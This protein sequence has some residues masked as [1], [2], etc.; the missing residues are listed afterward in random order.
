MIK[1]LIVDDSTYARLSI[2]RRFSA[3]PEIEIAGCAGDGLEALEKIRELKPDV[4][5][6]DVIMP[7]LDGLETL[8]RI[9]T[10]CPTP[11]VMLSS[12]T[13]NGTDITVRALEMGAVDFFLKSSPAVPLGHY[14]T[15]NELGE[16]V[17]AAARIGKIR[18]RKTGSV[19]ENQAAP[20]KSVRVAL[21]DRS[22]VVVVAS[23]TGGP[24]ALYELFSRI[25]AGINAGFLV[26]Q[27]MPPVFTASL[28]GRLDDISPLDVREAVSGDVLGEGQ[29]LVAP[30][31]FH[32]VVDETRSIE[33]K[34]SAPVLN[35]R[36]A[37]DVTMKSAARVYGE[38]VL[39]VVLTGMGT[40]GTEGAAEVK[41]QG[42]HV[43]TQDEAS[44]VIYGMPQSVSESGNSDMELPLA[45]IAEGI[46][47]LCREFSELTVTQYSG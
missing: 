10:E 45:R 27:H 1:V 2:I 14:G 20:G 42:G 26:V 25:P 47:S 5:T 4:V 7:R 19:P 24:G 23:S 6:L 22:R 9:M 16:K 3:D 38:K 15:A 44:C 13:G 41:K 18:L 35:L 29:V 43:I 31:D 36:P 12:L 30:G 11:V 39:G 34:K 21:S 46:E 32:M 8:H 28:A 17:K 40:D 37:A 33:L